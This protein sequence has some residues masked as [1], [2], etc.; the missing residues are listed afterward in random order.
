MKYSEINCLIIIFIMLNFC[1]NA[2]TETHVENS[3]VSN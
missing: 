3:V 2:A 1:S